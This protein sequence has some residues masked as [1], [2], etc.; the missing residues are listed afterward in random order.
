[1]FSLIQDTYIEKVV[2][3]NNEHGRDYIADEEILLQG[4]EES[5]ISSSNRLETSGSEFDGNSLKSIICQN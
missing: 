1:M 2:K 3:E 4:D 5:W